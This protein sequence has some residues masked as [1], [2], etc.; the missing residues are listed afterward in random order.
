MDHPGHKHPGPATSLRISLVHLDGHA[1]IAL[2]GELDVLSATALAEYLEQLVNQGHRDLRLNLSALS[3]LDAAGAGQLV[4]CHRD[5]R[6]LGGRLTLV[7][8]SGTPLRILTLCGLLNTFGVDTHGSDQLT[9]TDG[10][11]R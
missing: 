6:D 3:F 1:E 4:S 5:L 8:V 7:A 2:V 11:S 10:T 9:P